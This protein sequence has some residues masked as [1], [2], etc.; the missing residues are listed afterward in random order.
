MILPQ[1]QHHFNEKYEKV[2]K[3][4]ANSTISIYNVRVIYEI[5]GDDMIIFN[6]LNYVICKKPIGISS[7]KTDGDNDM[8][9]LISQNTN[10]PVGRI[11]TVHRLDSSVGGTMVYALGKE[12]AAKLS[13]LISASNMRKEYLAVIH[14]VPETT[15]GIFEDL[16]F[17]DSTKN[18]SFIV[19]RMRKGV[20]EAI[21]EFKLIDT[22]CF[23]GKEMS[24][25][26]I[27]LHTGRTHQIRVQFS[28]R[29]MPLVGDRRYGSGK[30]KCTVALW[31]H[32]ISFVSPFDNEQK[33]YSTIPDTENF[34][35][36]LFDKS[37]FK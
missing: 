27:L 36:N 10:I 22:V 25:V 16:L 5:H 7:Q 32:E 33:T 23:D 6:D 30:D 21:L 28:H 15:N 35:W 31:S 20:K 9:S 34:P 24:L 19:K 12:K 37:Y 3:N 17:K 1:K 26:K 4:I 13:A 29:K 2:V 11:H 8:P 18:K 14:G